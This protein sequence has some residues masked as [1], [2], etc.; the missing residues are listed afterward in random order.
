[1]RQYSNCLVEEHV[2]VFRHH[3]LDERQ[4]DIVL[5]SSLQRR[6]LLFRLHLTPYKGAVLADRMPGRFVIVC[7]IRNL[8]IPARTAL[9]VMGRAHPVDAVFQGPPDAAS[10]PAGGQGGHP[11]ALN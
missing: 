7:N 1:M 5:L 2:T 11:I 10:P 3:L 6:K 8:S 9:E 4:W